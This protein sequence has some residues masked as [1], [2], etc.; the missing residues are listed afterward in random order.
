MSRR[1]ARRIFCRWWAI[2]VLAVA[3]GSPAAAPLSATPPVLQPSTATATVVAAT[4]VAAPPRPEPTPSPTEPATLPTPEP[5]PALEAQPSSARVVELGAQAWDFLSAFTRDFSPRE[6]GTVQEK[7][8]SEFLAARFE[9]LGYDVSLQ[10]FKV[11]VASA[12]VLIGPEGQ[13]FRSIPLTR[14]GQGSVTGFLVDAGRA[15]DEDNISAIELGGKIALIERGL[16]TFEEKVRRVTEAGAVAAVIYNDRP[17]LFGGV[18]SAEA[19]IPVAALSQ[20]SGTAI[21]ALL[22][23]GDVEGSVSVRFEQRDSQN[24]IAE[25]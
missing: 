1:V 6:S 14:S 7:A 15:M 20:E 21:L 16:I 8:A 24:V 25:M 9:S 2:A 11:D 5:T 4:P 17:R 13:D 10:P 23:E 3:C 12:E 22:A 19:S 18:L